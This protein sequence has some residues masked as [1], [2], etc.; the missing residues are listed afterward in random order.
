MF[1]VFL[2]VAGI[3]ACSSLATPLDT[4]SLISDRLCL[5]QPNQTRSLCIVATQSPHGPFD[6]VVFYV[7]DSEGRLTMIEAVQGEGSVFG[8]A[9]F[10]EGG[11]FLALTWADEGHPHTYF[12][13]ADKYLG[14]DNKPSLGILSDYGYSGIKSITDDGQVTYYFSQDM[15]GLASCAEGGGVDDE[16]DGYCLLTKQIAPE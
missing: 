16:D 6:D 14:G 8:G 2:L 4:Q 3:S 13:S 10:S 9:E 1:L 12:Y 7:R 15:G 5:Q 11:R